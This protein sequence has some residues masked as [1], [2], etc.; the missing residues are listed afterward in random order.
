LETPAKLNASGTRW[1]SDQAFAKKPELVRP[2]ND[3]P[4]MAG[5]PAAG[6]RT[7]CPSAWMVFAPGGRHR[8][9]GQRRHDRLFKTGT[10]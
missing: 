6:L 2:G 8:F 4:E 10:K 1:F 5:E 7:T 9:T 3:G